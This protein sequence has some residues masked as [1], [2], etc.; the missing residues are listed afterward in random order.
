VQVFLWHEGLTS[1]ARVAANMQRASS[2]KNDGDRPRM[3]S[4]LD[5]EVL[6]LLRKLPLPPGCN[7]A[8]LEHVT[9]DLPHVF[10]LSSTTGK[11]G[12]ESG[13]DKAAE[14]IANEATSMWKVH[15][16]DCLAW[17]FTSVC[18]IG[19][20]LDYTINRGFL[21]VLLAGFDGI[22]PMQQVGSAERKERRDMKER[23]AA[24]PKSKGPGFG[25][26]VHG[27]GDLQEPTRINRRRPG[28]G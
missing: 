10:G 26:R 2:R 22:P 23:L 13:G 21:V 5:S 25:A 20:S 27:F 18:G 24:A 19:A 16:R 3:L 4:H 12:D 8:F 28:G 7:V 6:A 9:G 17:S 11:V 15:Q 14:I 1:I